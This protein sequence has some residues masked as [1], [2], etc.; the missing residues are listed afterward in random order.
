M[1]GFAEAFWA[2]SLKA[3]KSKILWITFLVF[4]FIAIMMGLLVF[5]ANNPELVGDSVVL[6]AKASMIGNADWPG[7]FELLY[8]I[9]AMIGLIGFGFVIS[10][11]FGREYVD[12]TLKDLLALPIPRSVIVL[13]KFI[14]I[15]IWAVLLS[16]T[17]FILAVVTGLAVNIPG[18][19]VETALHAFYIFTGTALLTLVLC[20][21]IAFL[22]SYGRGYL[23]PMGFI[24]L[25]III[26][27]FIVV[28][29]PGIAPYIPWAIPALFC[30]A[31]G[32]AGPF[33]GTAS[34]IILFIT[35]I[36]GLMITLAWWRFADAR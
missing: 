30:G 24:I 5:V 1:K 12:H 3:R 34:Y 15:T 17:L 16:L 6:S 21:P 22:A 18:W 23:L 2:E 29:I 10:W 27:Q 26:T 20:T 8:Q 19:S 32:P 13:S 36:A 28:G 11:V 33:I 9:I 25:I 7:Y 14:V 35:S 31:A 4:S